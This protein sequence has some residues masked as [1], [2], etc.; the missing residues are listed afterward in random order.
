MASHTG[1]LAVVTG[2]STG[3]G[4]EF[5]KI[6]AQDGYDLVVVVDEPQIEE[7]ARKL[8]QLGTK[9]E[10]VQADLAT[11]HGVSALWDRVKD[12]RV[13]VLFA[14]AGLGLGGAFLD[15]DWD[16]IKHVIEFALDRPVG[17]D[18]QP[19]LRRD[20]VAEQFVEFLA[21]RL[22]HCR[23]AIER[24]RLAHR[25]EPLPL[26]FAKDGNVRARLRI[27][28]VAVDEHGSEAR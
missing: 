26:R 22:R 8:G 4:Y 28:D 20:P 21:D 18:R 3:I 2:A 19:G 16:R 23:A 13:D 10:A 11:E 17:R 1:E 25:I 27:D 14:N 6:A 15:Q 24:Q 7:A 12:R 9:V 5:A